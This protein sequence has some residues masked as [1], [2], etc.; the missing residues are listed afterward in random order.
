[1]PPLSWNE[2]KSRPVAFSRD[3][4]KEASENAEAKT[5]WNEFFF[6]T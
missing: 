6:H 2:I 5:F 3:W 1:M 4:A